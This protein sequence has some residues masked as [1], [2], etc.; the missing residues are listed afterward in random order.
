MNAMTA[1]LYTTYPVASLSEEQLL[2]YADFYTDSCL[3]P[4]ILEDESIFREEAWRYRLADKESDLTIEGTVY[5]EM[6]GAVDINSEAYRNFLK[7]AFPGSTIGNVS[8]GDPAYIPDMT[9]ESLRSYHDLYYHPSNC[10][11]FLPASFS[12]CFQAGSSRSKKRR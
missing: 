1:P 7:T 9:W 5:S 10:C 4:L 12:V 3:H 11:A 8:G 6:L 2:K